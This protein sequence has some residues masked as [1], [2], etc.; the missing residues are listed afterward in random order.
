MKNP[1]FINSQRRVLTDIEKLS[2][3]KNIQL[4]IVGGF[5]RDIIL[6]REVINLDIDF[7]LKKNAIAFARA[8]AM[9]TKAGFVVLDKDK[10]CAR[11]VKK[12]KDGIISLDF[13]DFRGKD[14]KQDLGKRDFSINALAI[15]LRAFLSSFKIAGINRY[16]FFTGHLVDHYNGLSDLRSKVI[17]A[18]NS[19]AFDDDPLRVLRAFSLSCILKFKI[20]PRT[21]EL[22]K[23]KRNR[24][25]SVSF[26]RIRDELFKILSNSKSYEYLVQLDRYGILELIMPEIKAMR[27]LNQGPYH[28]LDT[29]KHTLETIRQL[30]RVIRSFS[31]NPDIKQYLEE[32]ISSGR[33]RRELIRLGGL[34][35][36]IG[37]PKTLRIEEGKVK[38]YG[39]ERV[40]ADILDEVARRIKLSNT[41]ITTLKK[42]ILNHLRPG[43][44]AD[45]PFLTQRAKFRFFSSAASEAVSVLLI[46]LADQRAT[47]GNLT[48]PESRQKHE[49]IVRRLI[50]DYFKKLKE[51]KPKR[52]IDGNDLISHFKLRPSP[53]IGKILSEVAEAQAIGRI[54]NKKEALIVAKKII[55]DQGG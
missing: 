12:G 19:F 4:Y 33:Y 20:E 34:L 53:L 48:T 28:H 47:R 32:E 8:L 27:R 15:D 29:W 18:I 11:I 54:K 35:H 31:R 17:R 7:A 38:F 21:L 49:R 1:L 22:A 37:K 30:D 23:K 44:L 6:D 2:Q 16:K 45:N 5:L 14:L 41:E 3:V 50:K 36:D 46:S 43:Y 26:E 52:L 55:N 39:H 10:G 42:M 51:K 40:G 25:R 13:T 9:K 24:L